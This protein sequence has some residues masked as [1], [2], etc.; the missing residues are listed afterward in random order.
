MNLRR[1]DTVTRRRVGA[2]LSGTSVKQ[3]IRV[4]FKTVLDDLD[5]PK[6]PAVCLLSRSLS[7]EVLAERELN[8][9]VV[10]EMKTFSR[11]FVN[12]LESAKKTRELPKDF[13]VEVAAQVI[14]TFLQG[15]F[16]VIRVLQSRAQVERQIEAL[17]GGLGL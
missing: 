16:R 5:D 11:C 7:S 2:L 1:E 14:F 8:Q 6:M 4:F 13:D 3:G 12:R 17:L 9:Y 10:G 15:L